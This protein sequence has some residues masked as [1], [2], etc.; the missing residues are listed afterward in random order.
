[1][2][3]KYQKYTLD[4][5]KEALRM[6][7]TGPGPAVTVSREYGCP[8]REVCDMLHFVLC[9]I[10]GMLPNQKNWRVIDKEILDVA[11]KELELD[12]SKIEYIFRAEKKSVTEDIISSMNRRYYKSDRKIRTTIKEV[13]RTIAERGQVIILGRAGVAITRD[14]VNSLHVRLEAPLKWR[15]ERM[16][17]K[18][19][20]DYKAAEKNCIDMDARRTHLI[21]D[22]I[23]H[24]IDHTLWDLSLNC[25][26]LSIDEMVQI[27][28]DVMR[29][30]NMI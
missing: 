24:P 17:A 22:F 14:M 7:K 8:S 12:P 23:G 11:A 6:R 10:E 5:D 29:I 4:K 28:V 21:S 20:L 30:R 26:R 9:E 3:D 16:A 15:A 25:N 18:Y 13:I 2:L 1:M 27:I 19:S